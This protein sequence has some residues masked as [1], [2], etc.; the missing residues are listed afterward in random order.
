M[1]NKSVEIEEIVQD[2]AMITTDTVYDYNLK[3]TQED[4]NKKAIGFSLTG[5]KDIEELKRVD[6]ELLS[7]INAKNYSAQGIEYDIVPTKDS[8]KLVRSGGL[9]KYIIDNTLEYNCSTNN[10][11]QSFSLKEAID[12]IP[13]DFQIPGIRISFVDKITNKYVIYQ[14]TSSTFSN[15]VLTWEVITNDSFNTTLEWTINQQTTRLQVPENKRRIGLVINY[16][17]RDTGQLI[18]EQYN[19]D[20][21]SDD[22]WQQDSSWQPVNP[23][24]IFDSLDS[25][26][27]EYS[28]SANQ[29]RVLKQLIGDGYKYFGIAQPATIPNTHKV[30]G[31][32]IAF[33][34][35]EYINFKSIDNVDTNIIVNKNDFKIFTLENIEDN[36]WREFSLPIANKVQVEDLNRIVNNIESIKTSVLTEEAYSQLVSNSNVESDRFYFTYEEN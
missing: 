21:T 27:T 23:Q 36:L 25:S 9:Y 12:I 20:T 18:S 24:K 19:T 34:Q 26:S 29:G 3:Q 14:N 32:Y 16:I 33:M 2:G 35:G 22:V 17:N 11:N 28:L 1:R 13:E 15:D 31:F 8:T 10:N 30:K 5:Y 6:K 7:Q 4:I